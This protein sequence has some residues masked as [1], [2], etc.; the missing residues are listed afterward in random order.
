[1]RLLTCCL[2]GSTAASHQHKDAL[3]TPISLQLPQLAVV[4]GAALWPPGLVAAA[5]DMFLG[6]M[7]GG[8]LVHR[9]AIFDAH[10]DIT[11][12]VSQVDV[13]RWVA[14]E[15]GRAAVTAACLARGQQ[16]CSTVKPARVCSVCLRAP[17]SGPLGMTSRHVLRHVPVPLSP[18]GRHRSHHQAQQGGR[19]QS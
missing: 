1:M 2:G 14:A 7:D 18:A 3:S 6:Q 15:A 19:S 4:L 9:L 8:R 11:H 12:I 17:G 10:G 16:G 5:R 13:L